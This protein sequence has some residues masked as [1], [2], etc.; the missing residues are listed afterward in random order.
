DLLG[1]LVDVTLGWQAGPDVDELADSRF[2][3]GPDGALKEGT[4]VARD[5]RKVRDLG[6]D[7]LGGPAIGLVIVLSA[8]VVV[9]HAGRAGHGRV[10]H[11][12]A[13]YGP[14]LAG[15]ACIGRGEIDTH[16]STISTLSARRGRDARHLRALARCAF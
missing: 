14:G 9:I 10:E 11:G 15:R 13:G 7:L 8:Q 5:F 3:E 2:G 16:I 12:H 1:D 4:V 6:I